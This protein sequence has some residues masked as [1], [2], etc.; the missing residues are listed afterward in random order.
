MCQRTSTH[1]THARVLVDHEG[2]TRLARTATDIA[3]ALGRRAE[4]RRASN[5]ERRAL[6]RDLASYN[7]EA[8]VTDLLATLEAGRAEEATEVRAIVLGRVHATRMA[9]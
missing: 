3:S 2:M 6:R 4:S 9:S 8:E 7:T 5:A 1:W